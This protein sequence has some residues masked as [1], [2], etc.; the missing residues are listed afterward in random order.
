MRPQYTEK[1]HYRGRASG[2]RWGG[3]TKEKKN[4]TTI[5]ELVRGMAANTIQRN[6]NGNGQ[7]M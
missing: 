5:T 1:V 6:N 7:V 3:N 4:S 2:I